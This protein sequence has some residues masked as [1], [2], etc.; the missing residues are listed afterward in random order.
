MKDIICSRTAWITIILLVSR[1]LA[2][3]TLGAGLSVI[4][5]GGVTLALSAIST[6]WIWLGAIPLK[7]SCVGLGWNFALAVSSDI[8]SL[9]P[10]PKMNVAG[11]KAPAKP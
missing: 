11:S 3:R 5:L 8:T 2:D 9:M 4:V 7:R 6:I 10:S 1:R